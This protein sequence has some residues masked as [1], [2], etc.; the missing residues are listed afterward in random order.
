[1][2][3]KLEVILLVHYW[4]HPYNAQGGKK[5]QCFRVPI[6]QYL[7]MLPQWGRLGA[8]SVTPF[9]LLPNHPEGYILL[10]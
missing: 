2:N 10:C 5:G 8:T 1:M 9:L 4:Y 7:Q 6:K 3:N